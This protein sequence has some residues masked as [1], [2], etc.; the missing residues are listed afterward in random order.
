[1]DTLR[2][3]ERGLGSTA[4][5]LGW[6]IATLISG[7]LALVLSDKIG[8]HDAYLTMAA[9]MALTVLFTLLAPEPEHRAIPPRTLKEAVAEPLKELLSRPGT[10]ALLALIVL[11]KVGDAF[12]LTLSTAFL[13]EGVGFT[14][15][16]VGAVAKTTN[17]IS[18]IVGTI[19]GGVLFVRLGLYRSLLMFGILQ[20]ITNLLYSLLA[21][22]GQEMSLMVV[23]V[24]FDNLAGGMGAAAFGAYLMALCDVR[25]SAFQFALLSALASVA[26]SFLGPP[27][28]TLVESM[29]WAQFFI[30]TFFTALPG[31]ALLWWLRG[32]IRGLDAV[33]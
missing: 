19:V 4:T 6:R 10:W 11:Y 17:I 28:A 24:G 31:L 25:F 32:R 33:K 23:A 22:A 7:A 15:A 21:A 5:Q 16:Q 3:A 13:I 8:W 14:A 29:G 26:R 9:I 27:A 1:T 18:T 12:A 2:P 20:A 30:V